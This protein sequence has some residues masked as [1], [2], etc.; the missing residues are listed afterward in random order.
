MRAGSIPQ[1]VGRGF[2]TIG[3]GE[4][5]ALFAYLS[6]DSAGSPELVTWD[7]LFSKDKS[8]PQGRQ[9]HPNSN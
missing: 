7:E 8:L 3:R 5:P 1:G 9:R 4:L 6:V 2:R